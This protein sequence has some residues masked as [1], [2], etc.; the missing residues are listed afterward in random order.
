MGAWRSLVKRLR[1]LRRHARVGAAG[2]KENRPVADSLHGTVQV[3]IFRT[4]AGAPF[5]QQ[6]QL[7]DNRKLGQMQPV[8]GVM[9]DG[10]IE[11]QKTAVNNQSGNRGFFR[12]RQQRRGGAHGHAVDGDGRLHAQA[13]A[14]IMHRA[15]DVLPFEIAHARQ[16]A[17]AFAVPA[18]IQQQTGIT[19]LPKFFGAIQHFQTGTKQ[20]VAIDDGNG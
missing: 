6:N 7:I 8:F 11:R 18:K 10:V 9:H 4:K 19:R 20:A 5:R 17:A 14:Q 3:K 12:C 15:D 13:V 2:N 16:L 1:N